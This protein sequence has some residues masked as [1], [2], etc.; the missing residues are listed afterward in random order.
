M[1]GLLIVP[2]LHFLHRA[3]PGGKTPDG[4]TI[5]LRALILSILGRRFTA[6]Q[7]RKTGIG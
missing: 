7:D 4:Y 2:L 6:A 3:C 5:G 1:A